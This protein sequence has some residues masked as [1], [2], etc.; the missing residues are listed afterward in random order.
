MAPAIFVVLLLKIL[1]IR[2]GGAEFYQKIGKP[3]AV[4][5]I[6]AWGAAYFLHHGLLA[7]WSWRTA[8]GLPM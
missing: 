4:G 7:L 8:F 1:T 6:F 2:I 5:F 3:L